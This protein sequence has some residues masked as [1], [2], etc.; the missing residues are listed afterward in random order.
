MRRHAQRVTVTD[1]HE[2][3]VRLPSDFP[4]GEAEV[5][6]LSKVKE[7]SRRAD[8]SQWLDEWTA[9]LPKAPRI[10]LDA[11]DRDDLYP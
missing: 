1:K 9:A 5:V 2:V 8:L 3:V 6:V 10:A 11:I 4:P 7:P